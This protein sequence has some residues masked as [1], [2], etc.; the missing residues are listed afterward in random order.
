MVVGVIPPRL[1]QSINF[2]AAD[3]DTLLYCLGL[4]LAGQ[5][6]KDLKQL[7]DKEE[8]EVVMKGVVAMM[9]ETEEDPRGML[10]THGEK[11][12]VLIQER[13][14]AVQEKVKREFQAKPTTFKLLHFRF[15]SCLHFCFCF[16]YNM[17]TRFR[18]GLCRPTRLR[19]N[20]W[21]K[22]RKKRARPLRKVGW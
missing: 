7:V 17:T 21:T 11:L 4:N 6:P 5:L 8:L 1:L 15:G 19:R 18:D 3:K 22:P 20:S 12:N 9:L 10:V 16:K 14:A 2:S 13:A